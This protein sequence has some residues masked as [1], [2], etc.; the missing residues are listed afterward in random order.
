MRTS[1]QNFRLCIN[2]RNVTFAGHR[3]V[4]QFC[5][6]KPDMVK[7]DG[8]VRSGAAALPLKAAALVVHRWGRCGPGTASALRWRR[9]SFAPENS[10][11]GRWPLGLLTMQH[12]E[13]HITANGAG[14]LAEERKSRFKKLVRLAA[15]PKI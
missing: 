7:H 5:L 4:S 3:S 11:A 13:G 12:H 8:H 10:R 14:L 1:A 6:S 15:A 2:V 9:G